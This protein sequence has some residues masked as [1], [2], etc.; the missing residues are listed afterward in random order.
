MLLDI[1]VEVLLLYESFKVNAI[2]I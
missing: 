1:Q 2:N